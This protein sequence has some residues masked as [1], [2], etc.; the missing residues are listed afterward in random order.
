V[1]GLSVLFVIGKPTTY[2]FELT[3]TIF[4]V[5]LGP[6]ALWIVARDLDELAGKLLALD[7]RETKA[8]Q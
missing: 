1:S 2:A 8:R 5:V 3:W 6:F 4:R 7:E